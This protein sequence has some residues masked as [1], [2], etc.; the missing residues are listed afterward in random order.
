MFQQNV[1]LAKMFTVEELT[2]L[3]KPSKDEAPQELSS[4]R[5]LKHGRT[6]GWTAG[7]LNQLASNCSRN[8]GEGERQLVTTE[9]CVVNLYSKTR[10]FNNFSFEG[11]SGASVIDLKGRVVGMLHGGNGKSQHHA[12]EIA[13]VTPMEWVLEQIREALGLEPGDITF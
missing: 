9:L 13:Y 3:L 1:T 6:S 11:D 12:L 8:E 2:Q 7:S 10:P 4:L 5:V